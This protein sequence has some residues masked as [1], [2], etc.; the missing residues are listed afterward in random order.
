M[1]VSL[2]YAVLRHGKDKRFVFVASN[3]GTPD[4]ASGDW[5]FALPK[6]TVGVEF[7]IVE[8]DV[9]AG[10]SNVTPDWQRRDGLWFWHSI[11]VIGSVQTTGAPLYRVQPLGVGGV[12][13][14]DGRIPYLPDRGDTLNLYVGDFGGVLLNCSIVV[15]ANKLR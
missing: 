15:V 1:S 12:L 4:P 3:T 7:D 10:I 14:L 6:Q 8:V 11:P 9:Y 5:T 13:R 2:G